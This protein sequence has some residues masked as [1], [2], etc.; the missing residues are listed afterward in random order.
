MNKSFKSQCASLLVTSGLLVGL[1]SGCAWSIG[2]SREA[3]PSKEPTK[4]Q[5]LIDLQKAKDRGAISEEEYQEQ[6]QKLLA[7]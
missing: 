1:L 7:R 6:K 4:G 2:S 3:P 5:Q